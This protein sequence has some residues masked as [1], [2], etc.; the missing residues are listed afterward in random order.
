[1]DKAVVKL[2]IREFLHSFSF[3]SKSAPG[4]KDFM[5][6][7]GLLGLIVVLGVV[8][9]SARDGLIENF[10]DSLL[11]KI[12]DVGVPL[13]VTSHP[14]NA[15]N[16]GISRKVEQ[17]FLQSKS[18]KQDGIL[19]IEQLELFPYIFLEHSD[20]IVRLPSDDIWQRASKS[21]KQA[22]EGWAVA[23][24]DPL[25]VWSE[26][27]ELNKTQVLTVYINKNLFLPRF[28]LEKYV[29]ALRGFIP[30]NELPNQQQSIDSLDS[31]WLRLWVQDHF[32][33]VKF[34]VVWL[35][36]FPAL[37][38]L[39]YLFPL[40]TYQA[41]ILSRRTP[42]R[43]APEGMGD[44]IARVAS[45][46]VLNFDLAEEAALKTV[47]GGNRLDIFAKCLDTEVE[48]FDGSVAEF[49]QFIVPRSLQQL[50]SCKT[51]AGFQAPIE[52]DIQTTTSSSYGYSTDHYMTIPC[53]EVNACIRDE[54]GN[55]NWQQE[56]QIDMY[57]F[58]SGAN[59]YV[60]NRIE[61]AKAKDLLLGLRLDDNQVFYFNPVYQDAILRFSYLTRT[62]DW[63]QIPL[64]IVYLVFVIALL[65][66]QLA[67]LLN[68]RLNNYGVMLAK[69]MYWYQVKIVLY[70]QIFACTLVGAATIG[71]LVEIVGKLIFNQAYIDSSVANLGRMSLGIQNFTLL[72]VQLAAFFKIVLLTMLLAMIV[73]EVLLRQMPLN[74]KTNPMDLL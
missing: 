25:R 11:G 35:D 42:F 51:I 5:S 54:K 4:S 59:V 9:S 38:K 66:V 7:T 72:P 31:I 40:E 2:S 43:F 50:A 29:A 15:I 16:K 57:E 52:I 45:I 18:E 36:S 1:L 19:D 23:E 55:M 65:W 20:P 22:F 13:W 70:I 62:L 26:P 32:E 53:S 27:V 64:V 60:E 17:L 61:L 48:L 44:N 10:S 41:S 46:D 47:T 8:F 69:G 58:F 28:N 3:K 33:L 74:K 56:T 12:A 49:P 34:K 37:Q 73:L 63:I 24:N 67:T 71:G 14:E 6:L 30:V 21:D 39:V 68:H